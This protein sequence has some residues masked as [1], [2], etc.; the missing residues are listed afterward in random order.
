ML[1]SDWM[2]SWY[3]NRA[4]QI[5]ALMESLPAVSPG[6]SRL[7]MFLCYE[8]KDKAHNTK[9]ISG[10]FHNRLKLRRKE[11]HDQ[12]GYQDISAKQPVSVS[13]IGYIRPKTK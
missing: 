12:N 3:P 10:R 13:L 4:K 9:L 7:L 11:H 2:G 1:P 8:K 6:Y 5:L